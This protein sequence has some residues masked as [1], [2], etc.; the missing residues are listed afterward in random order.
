MANQVD[1]CDFQEASHGSFFDF[2]TSTWNFFRLLPDNLWADIA[3]KS[4][5]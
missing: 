5:K 3:W 1:Q 2:L 4:D